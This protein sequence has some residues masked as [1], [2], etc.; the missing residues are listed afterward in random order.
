M[1]IAC[2]TGCGWREWTPKVGDRVRIFRLLPGSGKQS[3]GQSVIVSVNS[4][5]IKLADGSSWRARDGY[6]AG[7][8]PTR[9]VGRA[10]EAQIT[11]IS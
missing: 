5:T 6:R 11:P 3:L 2:D 7:S 4:R 9:G 1:W 10:F 8:L